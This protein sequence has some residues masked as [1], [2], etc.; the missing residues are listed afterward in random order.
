LR[1]CERGN[2]SSVSIKR[3]EFLAV[4]KYEPLMKKFA[5]QI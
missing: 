2:E 3:G 5:S 1:A 4:G